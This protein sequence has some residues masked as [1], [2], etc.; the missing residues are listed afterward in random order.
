MS[1]KEDITAMNQAGEDLY[2]YR[3][4]YNKRLFG[5]KLENMNLTRVIFLGSDLSG[6]S[7]RNST[8]IGTNFY[9]A[10]LTGADLRDADLTGAELTG[11]QLDGANIDG[12][13]GID[14][15]LKRSFDGIPYGFELQRSRLSGR[16]YLVRCCSDS[17]LNLA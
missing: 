9:E 6:A 7:F 13:V 17:P 4:A 16:Q 8:L 14:L 2:D 3:G 15:G 1:I 5:L 10:K 12:A 11:A